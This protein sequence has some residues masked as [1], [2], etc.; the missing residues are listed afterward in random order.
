MW[1]RKKFRAIMKSI[2]ETYKNNNCSESAKVLDSSLKTM[3]FVAKLLALL[4]TSA[5]CSFLMTPLATYYLK[6]ELVLI[7][8]IYIPGLDDKTSQGYIITNFMHFLFVICGI[9][10]TLVFDLIF[11]VFYYHIVTLNELMK[12]KLEEVGEYLV[13]NDLKI[14][15]NAEKVK[16]MMK[17]IYRLHQDMLKCVNSPFKFNS[18]FF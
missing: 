12:I 15:E 7:F 13:E 6:A 16:D 9:S 1:D 18:I 3:K 14:S 17:E 5:G 8:E 10:G 2:E 11:F 4:Y